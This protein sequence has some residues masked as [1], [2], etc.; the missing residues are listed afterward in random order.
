MKIKNNIKIVLIALISLTISFEVDGQNKSKSK[1]NKSKS[2]RTT[3]QV[4][5][6]KHLCRWCNRQFTGSGF[7][8]DN[9]GDMRDGS[10]GFG[11]IV[12]S[13][14]LGIENTLHGDFCSRQCAREYWLNK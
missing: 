6:E 13:G 8:I 7:N 1:S 3:Q 11:A 4:Q 12:G 14:L 5:A 10:G 2:R 9:K